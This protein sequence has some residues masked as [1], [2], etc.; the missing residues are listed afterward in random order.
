[1]RISDWSS[2]VC[3]SD[4]SASAS[5][6]ATLSAERLALPSGSDAPAI[7]A[8]SLNIDSR[9]TPTCQV[10]SGLALAAAM[11][12]RARAACASS[13]R[14]RETGLSDRRETGTSY[15]RSEEHTSALPSIMRI[16]YA[17]FCLQKKTK[18]QRK[19]DKQHNRKTQIKTNKLHNKP[20]TKQQR[21]RK[22]KNKR[23]Y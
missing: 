4:L 5:D 19:T 15:D 7:S 6:W 21:H 12:S 9:R 8:V 23:Q 14:P 22:L 18:P 11:R 10:T 17:V 20:S 16:S 1:M 3:S 2:D 13:A